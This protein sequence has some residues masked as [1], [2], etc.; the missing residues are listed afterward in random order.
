MLQQTSSEFTEHKRESKSVISFKKDSKP[1][2]GDIL[3]QAPAPALEIPE[4]KQMEISRAAGFVQPLVRYPAQMPK[5]A[6]RSGRCI[7][8]FVVNE[9]G[10]PFNVRLESC[11]HE[12]FERNALLAVS[13]YKYRP[14]FVEGEAT[15][16]YG[17]K[18]EVT[19]VLIDEDGNILP[20]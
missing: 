6:D 14:N 9:E 20:E 16:M 7:L 15:K 19:F 13:K 8:E 17:V 1:K 2:S 5:Q 12:M 10:T 4:L 3:K 18:T 11:T